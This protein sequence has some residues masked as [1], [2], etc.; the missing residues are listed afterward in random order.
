MKVYVVNMMV[1]DEYGCR[2]AQAVYASRED[3]EKW[4]A[5]NQEYEH[6]WFCEDEEEFLFTKSKNLN[7]S[8]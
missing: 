3:A 8:K 5:E 1:D 7:F 6:P 4:V 2:E